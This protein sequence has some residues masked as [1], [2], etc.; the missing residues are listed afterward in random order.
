MR[1]FWFPAALAGSMLAGVLFAQATYE[2]ASIYTGCYEDEV[3]LLAW[4]GDTHTALSCIAIDE[5]PLFG[6][7]AS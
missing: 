3:A 7:A 5:H 1:R 2:P 4:T 6:R